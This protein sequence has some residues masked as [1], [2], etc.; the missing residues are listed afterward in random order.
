MQ[1]PETLKPFDMQVKVFY[2]QLLYRCSRWC[3]AN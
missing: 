3:W 2:G 1:L